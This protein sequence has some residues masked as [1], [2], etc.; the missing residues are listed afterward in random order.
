MKKKHCTAGKEITIKIIS[1]SFSVNETHLS[2]FCITQPSLR[3]Q[4]NQLF[5]HI[6]FYKLKYSFFTFSPDMNI[7]FMDVGAAVK[8]KNHRVDKS[9]SCHCR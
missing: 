2:P 5:L 9:G 8:L 7:F 3:F 6:P 4:S 1:S